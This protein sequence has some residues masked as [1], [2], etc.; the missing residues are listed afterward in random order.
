MK[1]LEEKNLKNSMKLKTNNLIEL[2]NDVINL[3]KTI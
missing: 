3:I 2:L 1:K